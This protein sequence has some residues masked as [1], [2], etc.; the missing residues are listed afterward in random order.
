MLHIL[1][2]PDSFRKNQLL[3]KIKRDV[4]APDVIDLNTTTLDGKGL[5]YSELV[6]CCD[7]IPFLSERRLVIVHD[8]IARLRPPKGS[9]KLREGDQALLDKLLEYL[10]TL[11][12]STDLVLVEEDAVPPSHRLVKLAAQVGGQV[13]AF[14]MLRPHELEQWLRQNAADKQVSL[15]RQ[16]AQELIRYVDNNLEL[17]DKEMAKLATYVGPGKQITPEDIRLLV[18]YVREESI[19]DLV[20]ALGR[21][22][23]QRAISLYR[24]LLDEGSDPLYLMAMIVRQYR[25]LFQLKSLS[26]QRVSRAEIMRAIGVRHRFVANKLAGQARNYRLEQLERLYRQLQQLDVAIKTGGIDASLGLEAFIAQ[27]CAPLQA[28]RQIHAS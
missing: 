22:E 6:H 19:F 18:S 25:L 27:V 28:E 9:R 3:A 17:L 10:P 7:S 23:G 16:A 2:G 20:D 5:T 26:E 4:G 24:Q 15:T 12:D 13:H 1:H 11:P 21:R 8:L 14:G